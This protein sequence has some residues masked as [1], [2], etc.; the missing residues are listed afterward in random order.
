MGNSENTNETQEK[1]KLT[2][3]IQENIKQIKNEFNKDETLVLR[4]LENPAVGECCIIYI[5]GMVNNKLMNE[6]VIRPLLEYRPEQKEAVTLEVIQNQVMLSDSVERTSD[7]DKL[8]Q[9]IVYGDSLLLMDGCEEA[10]ILNTKGWV[11]RSVSEPENEKVLRGPREGF[12]E[13]IMTNLSLIRRKIRTS[14]LKMEFE[15]FGTRTNTKACICYLDSVVNKDVLDELK[16]RIHMF[17]IDG[18]LDSN[19]I[20]EFIKDSPY[21]PFKTAGIS[22]KPDVVAAKILEGRIALLL[23]G[24]P[25]VITVPYLFSENFQ[26]DEDYY[27]NYYF[28]SINRML[29][30]LAF[31]MSISVPAVYVALTTFHQEMLPL[32]LT[33]SISKARQG[34]PFPTVVEMIL[35]LV[36]FEMLRES[37][38]RMPGSMGQA[39]SIVG[40]L[41]MGQA[42]V[43]AKIVSAPMIIIVATTGICGLMVPR[44]KGATILLRF[45]LLA[46]SSFFGLYGFMFGILGLMV[47]LYSMSSFGL[48]IMNSV[49]TNTLQDKKD[50]MVRAPWWF[51]KKRPKY[52]SSNPT[53]QESTRS[54]K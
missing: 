49:Y 12:T 18:T 17:S 5:D 50:I 23:D 24:S 19:Y 26:S 34:V 16:K 20:N 53:R 27:L 4:K 7:H 9:A 45:V 41:V 40:A 28:A 30:Y 14:D 25:C 29:R 43:S 39:L 6:D 35:M 8:I 46:I 47:H 38:A 21:S 1:I 3:Q 13:S 52:L 48:P 15:T 37:G 22:E 51:M 2:K 36:I 42:A 32:A 31:I 10:L 44:M 54:S 33:M 11:S